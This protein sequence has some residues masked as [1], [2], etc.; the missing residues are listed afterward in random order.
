[1]LIFRYAFFMYISDGLG[2]NFSR[3]DKWGDVITAQPSRTLHKG[4]VLWSVTRVSDQQTCTQA[5]E[6]FPYLHNAQHKPF[7]L[8][9][10]A[11]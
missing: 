11:T 7:I 6:R 9:R 3:T 1:M 5:V 4:S 10:I 8:Q 2:F